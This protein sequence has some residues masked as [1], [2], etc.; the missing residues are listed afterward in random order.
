MGHILDSVGDS[1]LFTALYRD[2]ASDPACTRI[3]GP[4]A[5]RK[6]DGRTSRFAL[7]SLM[8]A[9]LGPDVMVVLNQCGARR[10]LTVYSMPRWDQLLASAYRSLPN[11]PVE[12]TDERR[13]IAR[14]AEQGAVSS[15]GRLT[16]PA[17]LARACGI[18]DTVTLHPAGDALDVEPGNT[19]DG[20]GND[21]NEGEEP[22]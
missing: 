17:R 11:D 15:D 21:V 13:R 1:V 18:L 8:A 3:V 9:A 19:L 16:I 7:P 6:A 5:T 2:G 22:E 20:E 4:P 10:W 12:Q 14:R